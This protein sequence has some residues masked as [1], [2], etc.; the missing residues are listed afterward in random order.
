MLA[1]LHQPVGIGGLVEGKD[2][3]D[4]GTQLPASE[5]WPHFCSTALRERRLFSTERERRVEPVISSRFTMMVRKSA[6]NLAAVGG[7]DMHQPATGGEQVEMLGKIVAAD[8]VEDGID[9]VRLGPAGSS[10]AQSPAPSL[11]R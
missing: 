9:T 10:A 4:N 6:L 5:Q 11:I 2:R 8:H 3:V 7:G 1:R